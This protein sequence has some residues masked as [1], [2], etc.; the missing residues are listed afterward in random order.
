MGDQQRKQTGNKARILIIDDDERYADLVS[1]HL[2][3]SGHEAFVALDG[4]PGL[5]LFRIKKPDAV[6]VDLRMPGLD[7]IHVVEAIAQESPETALIV[8][9]GEGS[10]EDAVKA[11]RL[12]AWDYIIKNET[13][14]AEIS[15]SLD[16]GLQRAN[17]LHEAQ[18]QH[19]ELH[20]LAE[21]RADKL[22]QVNERLKQ[23]IR[24]RKK[25]EDAQRQQAEFLQTVLDVLPHPVFIKNVNGQYTGC[26]KRFGEVFGRDRKE[27]IGATAHDLLD[28]ETAQFFS[29]KDRQL[30][31]SRKMQEY[32]YVMDTPSDRAYMLMRK[33]A[34][35]CE[36]APEG[37]VGIMTDITEIKRVERQLRENER[38]LRNLLDISPLPVIITEKATHQILFANQSCCRALEAET[39]EG[40][41]TSDFFI[42]PEERDRKIENIES[43]TPLRNIEFFMKTE[44]GREIWIEAS[45]LL[46]EY[47][48]KPA[49]FASFMDVTEH[50]RMVDTLSRYKFI[51]NAAQDH[52]T[53]VN[54]DYEYVA[55]NQAYVDRHGGTADDILGKT[56][57]EI[58]GKNLFNTSIRRHLEDCFT[59]GREVS[60]RAW[61]PFFSQKERYFEVRLYPYKNEEGETTH[62]VVVSRDI[63]EE[64]LAQARIM[65]SREHFRAIFSNSIDPIVL[66]DPQMSITDLNP[67]AQEVFSLT[68]EQAKGHDIRVLGLDDD[69]H[70]RFRQACRPFLDRTGSWIGEWE[71]ITNHKQ[72]ILAEISISIMPKRPGGPPAGYAAIMRDISDRKA[73]ERML[74]ET[75]DEM[76]ALYQNTVIGIAMTRHHRIVRINDRGAEIF[77]HV[78]EALL[79]KPISQLFPRETEYNEYRQECRSS[80][81]ATGQFAVEHSFIRPDGTAFWCHFYAKPVD[82]EDFEQGLI[83]TY[84]D[85][86]E[87]RYNQ[88]VAELLY[89]IS[90]AVSLTTDLDALYRRINDAL[91]QHIDARN[92]FI[93]LLSTD[94][95]TLIFEYFNDQKEQCLGK[96]FDM[97]DRK[98]ASMSAH[99]I[100]LGRPLFIS[101]TEKPEE[102]S[103]SKE[104]G[105]EFMTRKE[106]M[107]LYG[108]DE[109]HMLGYPSKVW[110]GVPL[111]VGGKPI[112]VMAVQHYE[113]ARHYSNRDID[114]L[115]AVSE[116][117]A[118]AIERKTNEQ[119]LREAK[120]LAEAANETKGEFL[121]NM[122]HEIR[123]PLNGVL[124]MLQLCQTTTLDEEQS[125]YV[126]TALTSGRGLLS[127]INDILD[128][129]KIEAG[130]LDVIRERFNVYNVVEDVLQTFRTQAASKALNL[131]CVIEP[132]IPAPLMG[133]K[134]RLRQI[135]FNLVGNAM[136]FTEHGSIS[137]SVSVLHSGT[138]AT[139][140]RLLF[141]VSDTG[142]GIPAEKL[143]LIFEPF[144]QVD[145]STMRRHQGT[146]LGLGIVKRLIGLLGGSMA[147][148][149]ELGKGTD[150]YLSIPFDRESVSMANP[151]PGSIEDTRSGLRILVVEDNRIN[152]LFAARMFG[153]LGHVAETACNGEEALELLKK[154]S[155]DIVFMDVQMPGMDGVEA[156]RQIRNA[157]P[158]AAMDPNIPIVAMTAHAMRG[159]REQFLAAG[160]DEYIAKPIEIEEVQAVLHQ[161]FPKA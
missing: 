53:L 5:E 124:G 110:L 137:V 32:E 35:G 22:A 156:T 41:I 83:W 111:I 51:A 87:R 13:V 134:G 25:A 52:M 1:L 49:T 102:A 153:K 66:F 27:I 154:R 2:Q 95:K 79:G 65:E 123:T 147:M 21:D 70:D 85:T 91:N 11:V 148:D 97:D 157:T 15:E 90:N 141:I 48:N 88:S 55:V 67:A 43:G 150:I 161:L 7:G 24:E 54:R 75:L 133:G 120:M 37:I 118:L 62:A 34:Y 40:R 77:G 127:I 16:K 74:R 109:N 116:Q 17:L 12:G 3:K 14:R 45:V 112:G 44:K 117:T 105:P 140:A 36:D 71:F 128:F 130:K 28:A 96:A 125:D 100:R 29:D 78:P 126:Q 59:N 113:N 58:W 61:I 50:K 142:I 131:S 42:F 114:L 108:V 92:F 26:N 46:I 144:T 104:Q 30:L 56:V 99:V 155:Y 94:R 4:G 31:E 143:D 160:M 63:T 8:L 106:F 86:T 93:A 98:I 149:S 10:L 72:I 76:E 89:Q 135:L 68:R 119:A 57:G 73:A 158:G 19:Q 146:G 136:K 80:V 139:K 33:A 20:R 159:N 138:N 39:L 101:N 115:I 6:L 145:G 9:S 18:R 23:E 60:Y 121:A 64:A 107:E 122:S 81:A 129:T 38:W 47:D 103:G 132:D 151:I 69:A 82:P 152:R 84:I